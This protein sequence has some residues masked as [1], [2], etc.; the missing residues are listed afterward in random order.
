MFYVLFCIFQ[1]KAKRRE[2]SVISK[3]VDWP[4]NVR[5]ET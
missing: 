1:N 5:T 2:G 3:V 4:S